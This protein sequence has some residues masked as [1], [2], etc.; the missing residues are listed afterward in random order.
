MSIGDILVAYLVARGQSSLITQVLMPLV[1][2][3]ISSFLADGAVDVIAWI[4]DP[5]NANKLQRVV[6]FGRL[7]SLILRIAGQGNLADDIEDAINDYGQH[8]NR[9]GLIDF[10][11]TVR[12]HLGVELTVA[13]TPELDTPPAVIPEDTILDDQCELLGAVGGT[14]TERTQG[15]AR[16]TTHSVVK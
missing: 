2:G 11:D 13:I 1:A 8:L 12:S 5:G 7:L 15:H 3:P 16:V 9:Q 6:D 10:A 4:Q 14:V